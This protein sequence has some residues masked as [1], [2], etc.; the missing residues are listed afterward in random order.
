MTDTEHGTTSGSNE[1]EAVYKKKAIDLKFWFI[2][3]I[4]HVYIFTV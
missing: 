4:E 3:F 2:I 1:E